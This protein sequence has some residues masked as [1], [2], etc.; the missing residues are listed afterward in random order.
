MIRRRTTTPHPATLRR[1]RAK[2]RALHPEMHPDI[3]AHVEHVPLAPARKGSCR[4]LSRRDTL[5]KA[6][7]GAVPFSRYILGDRARRM[8]LGDTQGTQAKDRR[9]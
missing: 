6:T 1:W 9:R 5:A 4:D 8:T 2:A 3:A 7:P